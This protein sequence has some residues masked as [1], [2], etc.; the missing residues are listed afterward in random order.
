MNDIPSL[1]SLIA[2]LS[3]ILQSNLNNCADLFNTILNTIN[4]ALSAKGGFNIPGLL[5]G[6]SDALPGYSQDRAFLNIT[7]RLEAAGI[8]T[9]PI[10]GEPNDLLG[11]IKSMLDGQTEEMDTN[12][13]IKV[14]NKEITI[15]TPVGPLIIPPGI[16]NSAGKMF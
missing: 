14:S 6:F 13:F 9:G 1:T 3:R 2:L 4:G 15:P 8:P 7:E 10:N 16:L 12:S 11:A 5:L